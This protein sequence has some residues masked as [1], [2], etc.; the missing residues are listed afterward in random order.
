MYFDCYF[1]PHMSQILGYIF[2][3]NLLFSVSAHMCCAIL[4]FLCLLLLRG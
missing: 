2:G 3:M 1:M 4:K